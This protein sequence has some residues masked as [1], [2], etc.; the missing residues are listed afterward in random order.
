MLH[1]RQ[2]EGFSSLPSLQSA[3][4]SHFQESCMQRPLDLHL[5]SSSPHSSA[6]WASSLLSPQSSDPSQIVTVDVQLPFAHWKT[7]GPQFLVGQL[8]DS[9]EPS[10]QSFSPSH[11]R[12][13]FSVIPLLR[14]WQKSTVRVYLTSNTKGCISHR[15]VRSDVDP[16]CSSRCTSCRPCP[17]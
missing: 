16:R 7:L 3:S 11:L 6:H 2:I 1:S 8:E 9:S 10:L 14:V 4:P 5:N 13:R 12:C 15:A 17:G